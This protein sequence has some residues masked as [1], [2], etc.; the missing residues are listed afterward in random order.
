VAA[1]AVAVPTKLERRTAAGRAA[2]SVVSRGSQAEWAPASDRESAEAVL[3][4]QDPARLPELVPLRYGRMLASPFA[5]YRGSAA[6]MAADLASMPSSGL[7]VQL[8]GD[9]HLANFGGFASPERTLVFDLNDFDE[10]LPGPFEWDVKRLAA[11]IEIAARHR[12]MR[13]RDRTAAVLGAVAQ[14]RSAMQQ[15]AGM[16]RLATWYLRMDEHTL[17]A[18]VDGHVD[19][20]TLARFQRTASKARAKDNLR[21][22]AKLTERK[23]GELRFVSTPPL[24][25]PVEELL[26]PDGANDVVGEMNKIITA[27]RQTLSGAARRLI[28]QYHFAHMARKVVGVGSVGTR[29]WV[30]LM[31]GR[32]DQDPLFLQVKE[33]GS[34]VLEPY[35]GRS[36]YS[37]SG[38]R[39]VEGQ[40]L[41]QAAS[42]IFLGWVR[43]KGIDGKQRDFYVR[44]L[45]D[46]KQSADLE[47]MDPFALAAYSRMCA[48]TLAH[49][50]ARSGDSTAIASYLGRRDVFDRAITEFASLYADQAESDYRALRKAVKD[51]RIEV[52][53]GL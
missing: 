17:L 45:W 49:A 24:L 8:C 40:W 31:T 39:V 30:V 35:A 48:W 6:V 10:T 32:D 25:V 20:K 13:K 26:P 18:A 23:D 33:A 12:E 19:K 41:M 22:L 53:L 34:S 44:Q 51:G 21:A 3:Q 5:F 38:R 29:A 47:T 1:A 50:H 11:S 9:A 27:Y 46:W 43:V 16:G 36:R 7:Q 14:Y 52:Q 37:H 42:D 28:E 4:R 2:R 15:F